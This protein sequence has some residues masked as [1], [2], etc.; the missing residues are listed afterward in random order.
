MGS[1]HSSMLVGSEEVDASGYRAHP[2]AAAHYG[3]QYS[4]IY[5]SAALSSA[6]QVCLFLLE[7][8]LMYFS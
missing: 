1:R 2:S 4:S 6:P 7:L 3:G 8:M 5:G